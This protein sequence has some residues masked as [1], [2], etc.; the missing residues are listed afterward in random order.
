M[1]R[2]IVGALMVCNKHLEQRALDT[3]S[4]LE[5]LARDLKVLLADCIPDLEA[6]VVWHSPT[7]PTLVLR[8][9]ATGVPTPGTISL[10]KVLCEVLGYWIEPY[11]GAATIFLSPLEAREVEEIL[12]AELT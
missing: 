6:E 8:S 11:L 2:R 1:L 12:K 10:G 4:V 3:A 5:Q 7:R 9:A